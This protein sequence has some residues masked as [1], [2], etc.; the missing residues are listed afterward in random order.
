MNKSLEKFGAFFVRNLR[1][2]ML[3]DLEMILQGAWKAP[4]TQELQ[5]KV[6]G[7]SDTDKQTLRDVAEHVITTGMHDLLF[8]LQ[9]Q[10]D[11][12]GAI[13]LLVDGKEVAKLSDGLHGEI[14]GDEGWIVKYSKYSAKA[15]TELSRWAEE[16]IRQMFDDDSEQKAKK[17]K[18][19]RP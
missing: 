17:P 16:Q 18:K 6:A 9:E 19:K 14:F 15:Q 13:R 4:D 7:L 10:A 8:A 2:K 1:D 11:A 5:K 12:D 3:D